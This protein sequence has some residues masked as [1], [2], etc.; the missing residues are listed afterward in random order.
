MDEKKTLTNIGVKINIP[1]NTFIYLGLAIGVP[2]VVFAI[3]QI[4]LKKI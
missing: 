3:V 2:L 4:S 1:T